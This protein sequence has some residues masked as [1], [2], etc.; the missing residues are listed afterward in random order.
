MSPMPAVGKRSTGSPLRPEARDF[1][2]IVGGISNAVFS[3]LLMTTRYAMILQAYY[4]G[5]KRMRKS[6]WDVSEAQGH[7]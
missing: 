4:G 1:K 5:K 2:T 3:C 6:K 7:K